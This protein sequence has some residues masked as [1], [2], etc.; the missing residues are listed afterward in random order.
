[1]ELVLGMHQQ[2]DKYYAP[3]AQG[4]PRY[5]RELSSKSRGGCIHCHQVREMLNADLKRTG[6][7]ERDMAYRYPLPEN[8][9]VHLEVHRGTIIQKV[10]DPSPALGLG[11]KVGDRLRFLNG[12]PL[13]SIAD[14]QYALDRAPKTGAIEVA[15][16]RGAET[17]QGK[18]T[19][20]E[21]W[22]RTDLSWRPSMEWSIPSARLSGTDLTPEEKK[23]LGLSPGQ[24]AFR[25]RDTVSTPAREA[26][27]QAG[28]IILDIDGKGLETDMLG[29]NRHV[30]EHYLVGDRVTITFLRAG[31]HEKRT[32]KLGR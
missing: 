29:F 23:T 4:K 10:A 26:G 2:A 16:Q 12:V 5:I 7:W 20:P 30:R 8:I 17:H 18:L 14:V 9:G 22:R 15:W 21:G 25:Q 3:M 11:L 31:K 24:L 28:D 6:A 1:M 13:H 32:M 27:I 19:L